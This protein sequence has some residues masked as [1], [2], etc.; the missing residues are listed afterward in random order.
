MVAQTRTDIRKVSKHASW[1]RTLDGLWLD[2][3]FA[4]ILALEHYG[5]GG[6]A[7]KGLNVGV[8]R[9]GRPCQRHPRRL[10]GCADLDRGAA[11]LGDQAQQ[12]CLGHPRSVLLSALRQYLDAGAHVAGVID[13]LE[14]APAK[15][16][17]G[18]RR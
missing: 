17:V 10:L 3:P 15:N 5:A 18:S 1:R 4:A 8:A 11:L 6:A 13:D 16:L 7:G 2:P 12:H 9:P 14:S